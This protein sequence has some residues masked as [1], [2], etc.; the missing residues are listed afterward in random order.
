[1]AALF[2]LSAA[3]QWNDPDPL[4]WVAIYGAA[5]A[6]SALVFVRV[7]VRPA[8][9]A[10]VA[11]AAIVWSGAIMAGGPSAAIY[12]RMFDGWEMSSVA[13]EE[14]REASGLLFVAVWMLIL[15]ARALR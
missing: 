7:H 8:W 15:C 9:F 10:I 5:C 4:R 14:A 13:V 3:V 11:L 6:L 12:R 2:A 1:M